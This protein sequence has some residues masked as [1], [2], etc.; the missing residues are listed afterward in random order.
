MNNNDIFFLVNKIFKT[1]TKKHKLEIVELIKKYTN[2]NN[3]N[4]LHDLMKCIHSFILSVS[5][6]HTHTNNRQQ[7]I[8]NKIVTYLKK[9]YFMNKSTCILDIGGGNGNVLSC[10]KNTVSYLK[11]ENLICIE[12]QTDWVESYEFS[13]ENISYLFWNNINIELPEDHANVILLMV[14]MHHMKDNTINNCLQNL[15]KLLKPN[16]VLLIKEHD[17]SDSNYMCVEL[18]HHL[19]H[20]NDILKCNKELDVDLYLKNSINNFKSKE[21]WKKIICSYNFRHVCSLNRFLD[22]SMQDDGKNV[23]NLYWDVYIK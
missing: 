17:I 15:Y 11:K 4:N 12:T 5:Y 7:Y 16:G 23:T 10:I 13:N 18:E 20:I 19:Y 22:N 2:T 3:W 1:L 8:S 9:Y 6:N 21:E 14:A